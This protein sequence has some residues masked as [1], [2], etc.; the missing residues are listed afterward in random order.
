MTEAN[1]K[2]GQDAEPVAGRS[3]SSGSSSRGSAPSFARAGEGGDA[4][5]EHGAR[6]A[7]SRTTARAA[8]SRR[9]AA[10]AR[11]RP[12][13]AH[14][15]RRERSDA[16]HPARPRRHRTPAGRAAAAHRR[17]RDGPLRRGGVGCSSTRAIRTRPRRS[18]APAQPRARPRR[19]A[20]RTRSRGRADRAAEPCQRRRCDPGRGAACPTAGRLWS[21][22]ETTRSTHSR[23]VRTRSRPVSASVSRKLRPMPS[24][25]GPCSR[26]GCTS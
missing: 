7:R 15:A 18:R 24:P 10:Q 14:R 3:R 1:V 19:R 25:S 11:T 23:S 17:P 13:G 20:V 5:G 9:A 8:R 4:A 12:Q 6:A 16:A 21:A 26:P 22:S 2:I